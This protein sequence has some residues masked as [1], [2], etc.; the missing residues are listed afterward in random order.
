MGFSI[1]N[2]PAIGVPPFMETTICVCCIEHHRLPASTISQGKIF[3]GR[4]RS[5]S[6]HPRRCASRRAKGEDSPATI[7]CCDAMESTGT[8]VIYEYRIRWVYF[9]GGHLAIQSLGISG[10]FQILPK[11]RAIWPISNQHEDCK[12][13]THWIRGWFHHPIYLEIFQFLTS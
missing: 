5:M 13:P 12:I 7:W 1:I 3:A 4:P 2:N 11:S 9:F 6:P 8:V 10:T